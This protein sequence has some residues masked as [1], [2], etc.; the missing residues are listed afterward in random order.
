M[1]Y[2][3]VP[4]SLVPIFEGPRLWIATAAKFINTFWLNSFKTV[5]TIHTFGAL[6]RFMKSAGKQMVRAI[7]GKY[8]SVVT[9]DTLKVM[10]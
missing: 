1:A 5:S 4:K 6:R 2:M 7:A 10:P 3:V 9:F 8:L